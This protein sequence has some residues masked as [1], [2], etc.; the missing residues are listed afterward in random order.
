MVLF[1]F[2]LLAAIVLS[3]GY[4]SLARIFTKRFIW[5]TGILNIPFSLATAIYMPS[6]K[7]YSG[8]IVFLL[9]SVFAIIC[10]VSWFPRIPFSVVML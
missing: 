9:F 3:Y 5:I 1:A 6:R 10:F 4:V 7:Y 2:C 8:G